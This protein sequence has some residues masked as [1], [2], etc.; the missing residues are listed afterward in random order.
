VCKKQ[1]RTSDALEKPKLIAFKDVDIAIP[2]ERVIDG[3][4]V[5]LPLLIRQ[6]NRKTAQDIHREIQAAVKKSI[7][8]EK[9]FILSRHR[10]SNWRCNY[11]IRPLNRLGSFCGG[12]YSLIRSGLEEIQELLWSQQ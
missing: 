2:I 3:R 5:P 9:D 7:A 11:T 1:V 12:G 4:G 6:T 10:F 8:D